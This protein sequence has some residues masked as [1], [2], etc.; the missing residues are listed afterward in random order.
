M[1]TVKI[2][3]AFDLLNI[4][5]SVFLVWAPVLPFYVHIHYLLSKHCAGTQS[6]AEK[7]DNMSTNVSKTLVLDFIGEACSSKQ[8]LCL[9]LSLSLCPAEMRNKKKTESSRRKGVCESGF[10]IPLF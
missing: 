6:S 2:A 8:L 7:T 4:L 1:S 5:F 3:L 10:L 9:P